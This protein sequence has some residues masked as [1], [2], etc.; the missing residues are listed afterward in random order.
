MPVPNSNS[1]SST[2]LEEK[3]ITP[4]RPGDASEVFSPADLPGLDIE[5][6]QLRKNI[7]EL[8]GKQK[9]LQHELNTL[10]DQKNT[11]ELELV[12]RT[13]ELITLGSIRD[14]KVI[15]LKNLQLNLTFKWDSQTNAPSL[16][17]RLQEVQNILEI[18]S[19]KLSKPDI[20]KLLSIQ[21]K[22][23]LT[24][25]EYKQRLTELFNLL[26]ITDSITSTG[27]S[28]V[29]EWREIISSMF[30][31]FKF[32]PG[33]GVNN[34]LQ[35]LKNVVLLA[36]KAAITLYGRIQGLQK[37]ITTATDNVKQLEL[38]N[39]A[40]DDE[41]RV[42]M[43]EV[44]TKQDV[45]QANK[46]QVINLRSRLETLELRATELALAAASPPEDSRPLDNNTPPSPPQRTL[47]DI[48][49]SLRDHVAPREYHTNLLKLKD[50]LETIERRTGDSSLKLVKN[51]EQ[52][53][54]DHV[55]NPN[56]GLTQ[57]EYFFN[58]RNQLSGYKDS[59][60]TTYIANALLCI[61]TL[62]ACVIVI[63]ARLI[64]TS[65]Q[66]KMHFFFKPESLMKDTEQIT[67]KLWQTE[68]IK[69]SEQNTVN[70]GNE[71]SQSLSFNYVGDD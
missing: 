29:D 41:L 27:K 8:T 32:Y 69:R 62:I 5:I 36:T 4:L 17:T 7:D 23:E 30:H 12:A 56:F 13:T 28:I 6:A 59:N 40:A 21:D 22:V 50:L 31:T 68:L 3:A 37:D 51:W 34:Y 2:N 44:A 63:P 11:L 67:T 66:G 57:Y 65:R 15:T 53:I 43:W 18:S 24:E 39:E 55:G 42:L 70:D 20:K 54:R 47:Q 58:L 9:G 38:E 35:E 49:D 26:G 19:V 25:E 14:N 61:A 16:L 1:A 46:V 33:S 52:Y 64:Y 10:N 45:L 60:L 71:L 48:L